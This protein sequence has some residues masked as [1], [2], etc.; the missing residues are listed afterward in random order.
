MSE[1]EFGNIY[2]YIGAEIKCD[3]EGR[4]D[5]ERKI[6]DGLWEIHVPMV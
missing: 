3:A 5:M 2:I 6:N 4:A 1:C